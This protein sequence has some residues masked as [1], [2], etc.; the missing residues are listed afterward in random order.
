VAG[1]R[2][3]LCRR[4]RLGRL[5]LTAHER[6][7]LGRG[8]AGRGEV[9]CRLG[10]HAIEVDAKEPPPEIGRD[11]RAR[12]AD[13]VEAEDQHRQIGEREV[14]AEATI[15]LAA[16]DQPDDKRGEAGEEALP[17]LECPAEL[18]DALEREHAAGRVHHLLDEANEAGPGIGFRSGGLGP[19]RHQP[20]AFGENGV[21]EV[22]L[23]GEA[24][25]DGADTDASA[26]GDLI[27]RG[28]PALFSEHEWRDR[29]NARL[30]LGGI[31][32]K[33]AIRVGGRSHG[34]SLSGNRNVFLR[35]SGITGG[36]DSG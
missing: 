12:G 5:G 34:L 15:A 1:S 28:A 10:A 11:G 24:A 29:E 3:G 17:V 21:H 36:G 2:G 35:L 30:V 27:H 18:D 23:R 14:G 9:G 33:G 6:N 25:I 16:F 4:G 22:F 20:D 32:A 13:R 26:T 31:A 7:D 8:E 19:L